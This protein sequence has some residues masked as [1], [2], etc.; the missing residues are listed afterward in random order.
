MKR[1]WPASFYLRN[2]QTELC[3]CASCRAARPGRAA[4]NAAAREAFKGRFARDVSGEG[5]RR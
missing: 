2:K 3:D 4:R 1:R 5:G